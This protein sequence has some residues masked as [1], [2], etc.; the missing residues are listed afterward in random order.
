MLD[1]C[2][3]TLLSVYKY[4]GAE[5]S[6]A[7][8][9]ITNLLASSLNCLDWLVVIFGSII[10]PIFSFLSTFLYLLKEQEFLHWQDVIR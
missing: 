2:G 10:D 5:L 3:E 8:V 6:A 7:G 9:N 1:T 4:C